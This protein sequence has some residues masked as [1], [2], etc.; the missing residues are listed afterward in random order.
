MV[1]YGRAWD[2]DVDRFGAQ[3]GRPGGCSGSACPALPS[4][5]GDVVPASG[6]YHLDGRHVT[7]V[8]GFYCAI[9]EAVNGSGGYFGWNIDALDDCPRGGWG[10]T[11]PFRL[12]WHD[13][14][15][16]R[17]HLVAG[18]DRRRWLPAIT[19]DDLLQLLAA[20]KS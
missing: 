10:A 8:E 19:L 16:A 12:V 5:A 3:S 14:M 9:G 20:S 18:Y 2:S 17:A 7:D 11:V 13:S 4:G 6:A 1:G 15:V